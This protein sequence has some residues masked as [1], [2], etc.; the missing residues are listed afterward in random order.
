MSVN[1]DQAARVLRDEVDRHDAELNGKM[2]T[3]V[4]LMAVLVLDLYERESV[5]S[6]SARDRLVSLA[7]DWR[8]VLVALVGLTSAF[9]SQTDFVPWVRGGSVALV[10]V[11]A[12]IFFVIVGGYEA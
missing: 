12:I 5:Q 10:F 3:F 4:Y 9:V 8:A 11:C 6:V 7:A 1:S 2:G